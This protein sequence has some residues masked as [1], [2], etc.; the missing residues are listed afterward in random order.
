MAA[1]PGPVFADRYQLVAMM[2][3]YAPDLAITQWP[4]HFRPSE[5]SRGRLR[6]PVE[7]D[8]LAQAGGFWLLSRN[9]PPRPIPGFR[10][11][12]Q[13]VLFDCLGGGLQAGMPGQPDPCSHPIHRWWLYHYV[14]EPEA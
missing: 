12:G 3:F 4:G 2:R 11:A 10:L 6:P 14:H 9:D 1:L 5:Y 13:R 7:R 8:E